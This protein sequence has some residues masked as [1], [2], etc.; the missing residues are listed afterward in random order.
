MV[1]AA[2]ERYVRLCL[3]VDHGL[4]GKR[5]DYERV[6]DRLDREA[7][8]QAGRRLF[9]NDY[10]PQDLQGPIEFLNGAQLLRGLR[11]TRLQPADLGPMQGISSTRNA[12][13]YEHRWVPRVPKTDTVRKFLEQAKEIVARIVGDRATLDR[14]LERYRVPRLT[15]PTAPP[16]VRARIGIT[17]GQNART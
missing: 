9:G 5:P 7:Y 6:R 2:L 4:G 13:E 10:R 17:G 16:L 3:Q 15:R 8:D 11:S 14:Q 12:C 1:Y